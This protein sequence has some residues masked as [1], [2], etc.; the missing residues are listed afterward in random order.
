MTDINQTNNSENNSENNS[1]NNSANNPINN[2][3]NNL[4]NT[5]ANN[6]LT[7]QTIHNTSKHHVRVLWTLSLISRFYDSRG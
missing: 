7:I 4:I 3:A 6:V 1:A 5:S 2:S